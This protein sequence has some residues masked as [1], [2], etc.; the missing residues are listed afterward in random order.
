[1][2]SNTA[3]HVLGRAWHPKVLGRT[4]SAKPAQVILVDGAL[5]FHVALAR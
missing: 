1:M 4:R 3:R 5:R 2:N